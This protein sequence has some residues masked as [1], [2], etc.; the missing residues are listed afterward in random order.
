MKYFVL[1]RINFF[2]LEAVVI[3][4]A[5]SEALVFTLNWSRSYPWALCGI[6]RLKKVGVVGYLS[7]I[8]L[9]VIAAVSSRGGMDIGSFGGNEVTNRG[10]QWEA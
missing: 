5:S 4:I 6:F 3:A 2:F 8:V 9:P 10:R 1:V 7:L